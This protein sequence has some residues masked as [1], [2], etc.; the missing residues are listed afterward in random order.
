MRFKLLRALPALAAAVVAL[1][2]TAEPLTL[3]TLLGLERF[4]RVGVDPSGV[5]AVFEE[6]R[7]QADLPRYDF[8]A[9]GALRYARL[10]VLDLKRGSAPRP[11]FPM[12]EDAGYTLGPFSPSGRRVVVYRLQG[13]TW[14]LGLF[15]F[16]EERVVWTDV[17]P[18]TGDWGRSVQWI[19]DDRLVAIGV[20]QGGLPR[21]LRHHT[22]TAS[23]LPRLWAA[24]ARGEAAFVTSSAEPT[25]LSPDADRL[26]L[27]IDAASGAPRSLARGP[28]LDL[29]L[30]PDGRTVALLRDGP[31]KPPPS[32]GAISGPQRDRSLLLVDVQSGAAAEPVGTTD[33]APSLMSWSSHNDLLVVG[34]SGDRP[35]YLR[36]SPESGATHR[37]DADGLAPRVTRD[38]FGLASARGG[39]LGG[40]PLLR[41][42]R[43]WVRLSETGPVELTEIEPEARLIAQGP[44]AVLFDSQETVVRVRADG[45]TERLGPTASA[46]RADGPFGVRAL[47]GPMGATSGVVRTGEGRLCRIAAS[48][49]A[50][51]CVSAA[52][53]DA[54]SWSQRR[55]LRL[56]HAGGPDR[57]VLTDEAGGRDVHVLN[58]ELATLDLTPPQRIEGPN[59][60]G[61]WLYLPAPTPGR[62][63]VVVIPY[64]G[65][66]FETP[67]A[68]MTAAGLSLPLNGRLLTARG[69]AVLFPDLPATEDPGAGLADR[70]LAVVDAAA[71]VAPVDPDRIGLWGWSFGSW[72]A[73]LSAS[74]SSRFA[75]VVALNGSYDLSSVIG[76]VETKSRVEGEL[77]S[78]MSSNAGWLEMGQAA[79]HRPYWEDPERY[80]RNSPFEQAS[81]IHAPMLMFVGELD[82]G[83]SQSEQMYGALYRL[84]RPVALT[85]L[86]G[87]DHGIQSPG[88]LQVYYEQTIGWF[89]R[90]LKPADAAPDAPTSAGSRPRSKPG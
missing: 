21:R 49:P 24:T 1:P 3:E 64:Q 22:L 83:L 30:S 5:V 67:P 50:P 41:G 19:D 13:E 29:E 34:L 7:A 35:A 25:A 90:Y 55:S 11:L 74:Q 87:E 60:A 17:S 61:G 18:E 89:D 75:A 80:R 15:D 84:G 57:L 36:I 54:V 76:I 69:F 6:R 47:S 8:L 2:A 78:M 66:T 27:A 68:G 73:A 44:D 46:G 72:T 59:G 39:W 12:A 62:A 79:M 33:I 70:I 51:T 9:E 77:A 82:F 4:G 56:T 58:P 81:R 52:P 48:Q 16:D 37:L 88:N 20:P 85:H 32:G 53:G 31:V 14:R 10:Y 23:R 65:Q 43:G 45:R 38:F 40:E 42:D 86:F 63:P 71:R 26:L 28:F